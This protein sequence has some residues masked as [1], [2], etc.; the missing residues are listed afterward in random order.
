MSRHLAQ[1]TND[2]RRR[3]CEALADTVSIVFRGLGPKSGRKCP[4]DCYR[5]T[6]LPLFRAFNLA[7]AARERSK[8][9]RHLSAKTPIVRVRRAWSVTMARTINQLA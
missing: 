2:N 8:R 5:D 7:R 4:I 6:S 3:A 9:L 1:S